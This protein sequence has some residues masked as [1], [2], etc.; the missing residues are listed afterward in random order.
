[1]SKDKRAYTKPVSFF[2]FLL[3]M[4]LGIQ[5]IG[6]G[7]GGG[8][9]S[10]TGTGGDTTDYSRF[11][12]KGPDSNYYPSAVAVSS[13]RFPLAKYGTE[14]LFD[15]DETTYWA[16]KPGL[17]QAEQI[18]LQFDSL[19][20]AYCKIVFSQGNAL[21]DIKQ[22]RVVV[23]DSVLGEVTSGQ[24]LKLPFEARRIEIMALGGEGFN[25]VEMPIE[26]DTTERKRKVF[27]I[28]SL[29]YN[30]KSWGV[31]EII[32]ADAAKK[33]LPV[34]MIPLREC[35]IKMAGFIEDTSRFVLFD[36]FVDQG[37]RL[38]PEGRS[39]I[40]LQFDQH[41][42]VLRVRLFPAFDF[43]TG[44]RP[45]AVPKEFTIGNE[46]GKTSVFKMSA[47]PGVY[48]ADTPMVGKNMLIQFQE[49]ETM[50]AG[51]IQLYDGARYYS[52]RD[53]YVRENDAFWTDSLK[54]THLA[55]A[56]DSRI[57]Q[58]T[59]WI[60]LNTDT[61]RI[62]NPNEVPVSAIDGRESLERRMS[63][64][65]NGTFE[66]QTI[67]SYTPV[68]KEGVLTTTEMVCTGYW[69]YTGTVDILSGFTYS[70]FCDE[71]KTE[72]G[73]TTRRKRIPVEGTG[74]ANILEVNWGTLGAILIGY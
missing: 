10:D 35:A 44:K 16:S 56:L 24:W 41:T 25:E 34:K 46:R 74:A 57:I 58:K 52:V 67:A 23:N 29:A 19:P 6:A 33:A 8:A 36:G 27:D 17:F 63:L 43:V 48:V 14:L 22:V 40:S 9:R 15:G 69:R 20:A 2:G 59:E 61:I 1:M 7:C 39:S 37:I 38:R 64:R 42:P 30:S 5:L 54:R 26:V 12:A 28:Y 50:Y 21:A 72:D 49:G 31:N 68:S 13:Q 3:T 62:V 47:I 65:S 66:W 4:L 55:G 32:F 70:G 60:H 18:S 73:K 71:T 45:G 51:E 11:I 53:Y